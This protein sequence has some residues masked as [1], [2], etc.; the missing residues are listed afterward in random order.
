MDQD[1][2]RQI[3]WIVII[4]MVISL[5]ALVVHRRTE[6]DK[7]LHTIATR[8]PE[9]RARAAATLVDG[10]KLAE[11]LEDQPRWVQDRAVEAVSGLGTET[12]IEQLM[13]VKPIADAPVAERI[14]AYVTSLGERAVG[15]LV[16][17]MQDKDAAIRGAASAPLKTI[18]EPAV[19]SLMAIIDVYDN[20]VRGLV[21][22]TLGGI[23][24]PAVEPLLRVMKQKEPGPDQGPAAFRRAREAS[25]AAFKAMGE[26]ALEP[27]IEE[28]LPHQSPE[29]RLAATD[30]LG[31][32][33]ATLDEEVAKPAVPPLIERL[34]DDDAWPVRRKAASALGGLADTAINN[35]AVGP[36]TVGLADRRPEVRASAAQALGTLQAPEAAQPLADLLLTNRIGATAEIAA[37]LEKIGQPS[38]DPLKPALDHPE[39][40]VRL[41]AT[42]TLATIG[43]AQA[44]VPLGKA[45]TDTEVKVRRVA[46][47]ALRNL[48]DERV[49]PQ[50]SDALGDDDSAVYYAARDALA[51]M[52]EPAIPVLLERLASGDT[53]I[54]YIAEQALVRIGERAIDPL[55]EM[56]RTTT[57]PTT[58][59]W[60]AVTLGQIGADSV[61]PASELLL[62]SSAPIRTRVGAARALGET[63]SFAATDPLVDALDAGSADVRAAAVRAIAEIGDDRATEA[64]VGALQDRSDTVRE[65]TME[66]LVHWRL[67]EVDQQLTKLLESGDEDASRRAAIVLADHTPAA[68]GELIR[69]IGATEVEVIKERDSVR[70]RLEETIEDA[71]IGEDLRRMA[72]NALRWVGT[73]ASLDSLA[74]L[75]SV[76]SD[77][78]ASASKT[79]GHIG[80]RLAEDEEADLAAGQQA[81]PTQATDLLL[82]VFDTAATDDLRLTAAAGLGVMGGQAVQPLIEMLREAKDDTERAWIIATLATTG[83]PAVD[84]ILDARGR[85]DDDNFR[86]WLLSALVLIGDAKA[87]DLIKQLPEDEQPDP[88]NT[89]AGR[90]VQGRILEVM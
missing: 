42:Q 62:S 54:A 23:G 85:A 58:V 27:V 33:A 9:M 52:G 79:I 26:T 12:A 15:P 59:R 75:V 51:R 18:G 74:P 86:N 61:E 4:V 37:A 7:L 16:L 21:S 8:P 43:T 55:I 35:N 82:S 83:K 46:A 6:V 36:L 29:V 45:L 69:T 20:A 11:A 25:I 49:L 47:D 78:A 22:T 10:Q 76:G 41:T 34:E 66:V 88:E 1:T 13:A 19:V 24:E 3:T 53:R 81:Q 68:S 38:I 50:L 71:S 14:D 28:L 72:I 87:L 73:E 89:R 39:P 48:A 17:A 84:P 80:Q 70:V 32:V 44:V 90:R 65:T 5:V 77:F 57:D 63:G 40:E 2:R 67:G 64:L 56:M 60:A 30:I 31:A